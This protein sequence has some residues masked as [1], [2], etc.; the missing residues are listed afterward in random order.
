MLRNVA[1]AVMRLTRKAT[2]KDPVA[3]PFTVVEDLMNQIKQK[4][5]KRGTVIMT[6]LREMSHAY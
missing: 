3:I 2:S 1:V 5:D 6:D 4:G